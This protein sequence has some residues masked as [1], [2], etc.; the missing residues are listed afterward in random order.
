MLHCNACTCMYMYICMYMH[1]YERTCM[2]HMYMHMYMHIYMHMYILCTSVH[3]N[4][5]IASLFTKKM[6]R[7]ILS[8]PTNVHPINIY[9]YVLYRTGVFLGIHF[10]RRTKTH[11]GVWLPTLTALRAESDNKI[12]NQLYIGWLAWV[13]AVT[14]A[15]VMILWSFGKERARR[16][17]V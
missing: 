1:M 2:M 14:A 16:G 13:R 5:N 15:V 8:K 6:C 12:H 7:L 11:F 9:V 17:G 3:A 4:G 10:H